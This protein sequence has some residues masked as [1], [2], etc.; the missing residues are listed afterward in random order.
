MG[1]K[2]FLQQWWEEPLYKEFDKIFNYL[3]NMTSNATLPQMGLFQ[4]SVLEWASG[5]QARSSKLEWC[6]QETEESMMGI[7]C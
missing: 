5:V 2:S 3:K 1:M 4:K 6:H 7:D